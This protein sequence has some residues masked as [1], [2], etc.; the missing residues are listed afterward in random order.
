MITARTRLRT[1]TTW[2]RYGRLRSM[3]ITCS[4]GKEAVLNEGK[5]PQ[6]E[7]DK[8]FMIFRTDTS[9]L[10][11]RLTGFVRAMG[12]RKYN[13][14]TQRSS[15]CIAN[16]PVSPVLSCTAK[17]ISTGQHASLGTM[18]DYHLNPWGKYGTVGTYRCCYYHI[19]SLLLV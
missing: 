6:D 1:T 4:P 8:I 5:C 13:L 10:M 3:D 19:L 7:K 2:H 15:R 14:K 16:A 11:A 18:W 12:L 17:E 9:A